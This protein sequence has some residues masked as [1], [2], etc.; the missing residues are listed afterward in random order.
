MVRVQTGCPNCK[1]CTNSVVGE[2]GRKAG[3][4][5]MALATGGISEAVRLGTRDCRACGHKLSLHSAASA[6]A[7]I[8]VVVSQAAPV[9]ASPTAIDGSQARPPGWY[10]DSYGGKRFWDGFDWVANTDE[11]S[12]TDSTTPLP[13]T[14]PP[15]LALPT[16]SLRETNLQLPGTDD[17]HSDGADTYRVLDE[18]VLAG[19]AAG[20]S[21]S[22]K[23]LARRVSLLAKSARM[24]DRQAS[25]F[26]AKAATAEATGKTSA[27][28][29]YL[30]SASRWRAGER[31][32]LAKA[33]RLC[34]R[35]AA[36]EVFT[37]ETEDVLDES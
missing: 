28:N 5:Y 4:G 27:S 24:N 1:R 9:S 12:E 6:P 3:R 11:R 14:A 32:Q 16:E 21:H 2:T 15:V 17:E 37:D 36:G 26:E 18:A 34:E 8:N 10:P 19:R 31:K 13:E 22:Q 29:S 35:L 33:L 25:E 30:R 20:A 7:P 23:V